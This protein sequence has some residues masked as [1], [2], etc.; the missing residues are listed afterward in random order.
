[1][2]NHPIRARNFFRYDATYSLVLK[3]TERNINRRP[4][5]GGGG[6]GGGKTTFGF[7]LSDATTITRE[8]YPER[9]TVYRLNCTLVASLI[10]YI[11]CVT[12]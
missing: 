2:L 5:G 3:L 9:F 12:V 10:L 11:V 4:K 8:R 6:G 7:L 1:M